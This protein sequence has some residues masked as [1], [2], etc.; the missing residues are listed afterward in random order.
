M[1]KIRIIIPI[2]VLFF[3]GCKKD[4]D[5]PTN[6]LEINSTNSV[7]IGLRDSV[8]YW[9]NQIL[10]HLSFAQLSLNN[11]TLYQFR[12][13]IFKKANQLDP[14]LFSDSIYQQIENNAPTELNT[15]YQTIHSGITIDDLIFQV[16]EVLENKGVLRR[17]VVSELKKMYAFKSEETLEEQ[18]SHVE[19]IKKKGI[20]KQ[21]REFLDVFTQVFKESAKFWKDYRSHEKADNKNLTII[22]ADAV[23]GMYG[24]LLGPVGSIV[25]GALFSTIAAIQ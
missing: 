18:L 9:H 20:N 15:F 25:E 7:K 22:W 24:L 5:Q 19:Y 2:V 16:F 4:A 23:G 14:K 12:S 13:A 1:H 10:S 8:G 17:T 6:S 21:E 11:E 3:G